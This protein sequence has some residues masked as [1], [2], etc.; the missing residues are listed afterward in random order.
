MPEAA[1]KA[2]L[3]QAAVEAAVEVAVEVAVEPAVPKTAA[4]RV[5]A[6]RSTA[7]H[8]RRV[9]PVGFQS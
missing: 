6:V 1:R 4:A 8:P 2:A 7:A 3:E 9:G 5:R